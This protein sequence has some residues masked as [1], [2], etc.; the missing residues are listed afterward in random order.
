[1]TDTLEAK[2]AAPV[3]LVH[4]AR[5]TMGDEALEREVLQLFRDHSVTQLEQL[6]AAVGDRKRWHEATHG[7]KG[8]ARGV[9]AW[10]LATA[11]EVAEL[12]QVEPSDIHMQ[13][14]VELRRHFAEANAFIESLLVSR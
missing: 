8:A 9:G 6:D 5:Y 4:L 13:H 3:D 12:D 10:A 11:A 7:I 14:V 1:M 2:A